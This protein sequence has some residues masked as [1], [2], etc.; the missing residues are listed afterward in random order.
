MSDEL[1][2][3]K[4]RNKIFN[5]VLK[6]PG[7]NT[8]HICK[9]IKIPRSTLIYHLNFLEKKKILKSEKDGKYTRYY[10]NKSFGKDEEK[11]ITILRKRPLF[12]I[13]LFF[14][15]RGIGSQKELS[16]YLYKKPATVFSHLKKLKEND[17]IEE[18]KNNDE[19][20]FKTRTEKEI[21][22]NVKNREI[23]YRLKD[24]EKVYFTILKNKN[25]FLKDKNSD[26]IFG[27]ITYYM[28]TGVPKKRKYATNEVAEVERI[29]YEIFPHPYYG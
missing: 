22:K 19:K 12:E 16:H 27:N 18:I 3:L 8:S 14:M 10:L 2:E 7:I 23:V 9:S 15:Y 5:Y 20:I 28:K 13:I 24:P 1:L 21:I 25:S 17:I 11:T 6:N 29:I 26:L 4:V